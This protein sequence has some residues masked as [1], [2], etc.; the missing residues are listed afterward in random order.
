LMKL[1]DNNALH[2]F[3]FYCS[4]FSRSIEFLIDYWRA[5]FINDL[6]IRFFWNPLN[7]SFLRRSERRV[8]KK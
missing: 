6:K 7:L 4:I 8:A 3:V 5:V 1:H 2:V